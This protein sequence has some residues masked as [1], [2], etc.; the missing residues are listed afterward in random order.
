MAPYK[1]HPAPISVSYSSFRIG[2]LLR[3]GFR[4]SAQSLDAI[5]TRP[6]K[7]NIH[8]VMYVYNVAMCVY[9]GRNKSQCTLMCCNRP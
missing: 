2:N 1:F 7:A 5:N 4:N 8:T 3:K 6:H 9:L